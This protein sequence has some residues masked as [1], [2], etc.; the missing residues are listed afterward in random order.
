MISYMHTYI[1]TYT[2]THR[3]GNVQ[4]DFCLAKHTYTHTYIHTYT[5]T[6]RRGNVQ[7]DYCLAKHTHTH[8]HTHRYIHTHIYTH[9]QARQR[10]RRLLPGAP[11]P[12]LHMR[13]NMA[14]PNHS[15]HPHAH[16]HARTPPRAPRPRPPRTHLPPISINNPMQQTRTRPTAI[17]P[18]SGHA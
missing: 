10:T 14:S 12:L 18:G 16:T 13:R 11:N 8:T 1:P 3:R 4:E 5:H 17:R 6:H 15:T 7:E 2:H 9:T